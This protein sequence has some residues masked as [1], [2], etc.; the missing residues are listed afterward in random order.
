MVSKMLKARIDQVAHNLA[1]RVQQFEK[2]SGITLTEEQK[3][4]I[5]DILIEKM[6]GD[7]EYNLVDY[8]NQVM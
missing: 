2:A 3:S 4:D 6:L 8:I 5:V 7:I 1:V